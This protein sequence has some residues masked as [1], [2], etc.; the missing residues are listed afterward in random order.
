MKVIVTLDER[1]GM[2]FNHRRQSRDRVLLEHMAGLTQGARLLMNRYSA[3]QFSRGLPENAEVREDF[4]TAAGAGDYCFVED[5]ALSAFA[6]S[7]TELYVYRWN[8]LYPADQRLDL[9]TDGWTTTLVDEFA[10][11]SHPRISLYRCTRPARAEN[12]VNLTEGE[13]SL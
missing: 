8:R 4:L 2:M 7:V 5:A 13:V 9:K 11:S 3:A 6:S 1:N 10:G 12:E